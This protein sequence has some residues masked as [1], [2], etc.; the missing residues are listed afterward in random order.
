LEHMLSPEQIQAL[1][2]ALMELEKMEGMELQLD[3]SD[4]WDAQ[5]EASRQT[6]QDQEAVAKDRESELFDES[7]EMT[8]SDHTAG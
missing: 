1:T 3:H 7:S 8:A 2:A 5:E 4:H 6:D